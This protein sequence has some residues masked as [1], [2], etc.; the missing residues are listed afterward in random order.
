MGYLNVNIIRV[1]IPKLY[2]G[3][4]R[5]TIRK[6]VFTDYSNVP[7]LV[8]ADGRFTFVDSQV[9]K[10]YSNLSDA[11]GVQVLILYFKPSRQIHFQ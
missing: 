10:M 7:P 1:L 6:I 2:G 5:E 8:T 11:I 4:T 3:L 9:H